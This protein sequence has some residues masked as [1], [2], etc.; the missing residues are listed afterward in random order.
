MAQ[1]W[2]SLRIQGAQGPF[3]GTRTRCTPPCCSL[4]ST[5]LSPPIQKY[6]MLRNTKV[7]QVQKYKP[8][9]QKYRSIQKYKPFPQKYRSIQK[10]TH[11]PQKYR[12]FQIYKP[13]PQKY[14]SIQSTNLFLRRRRILGFAYLLLLP[15]VR[16]VLHI[17]RAE[18][19]RG[20]HVARVV[21]RE[22]GRRVRR[23]LVGRQRGVLVVVQ[24]R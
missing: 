11:F 19:A 23:G 18:L 9:P 7:L 20:G 12:S 13:F 8:F 4:T 22:E 16:L 21:G 5:R 1:Q 10:Y 3:A 24:G 6:M 17:L 15:C 14:R 2:S